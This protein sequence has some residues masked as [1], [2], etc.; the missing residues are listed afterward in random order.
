MKFIFKKKT[1]THTHTQTFFLD[2]FGDMSYNNI[3]LSLQ[4]NICIF[5]NATLEKVPTCPKNAIEMKERS[6]KKRCH[7]LKHCYGNKL[8]Y[9]CTRDDNGLVEVCAPEKK[10][11]G[12]AN[13]NMDIERRGLIT[14]E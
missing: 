10:I 13:N 8:V 11:I 5:S 14:P 9:H 1:K 2:Q 4:E 3:K 6:E 12:N 7:V